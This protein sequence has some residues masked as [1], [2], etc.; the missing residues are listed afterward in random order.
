MNVKSFRDHNSIPLS[1]EGS[2]GFLA[3]LPRTMT[4][5]SPPYLVHSSPG[6]LL[7]RQRICSCLHSLRNQLDRS[8]TTRFLHLR[9][10]DANVTFDK[11]ITLVKTLR[12]KSEVSILAM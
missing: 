10:E 7:K 9:F 2:E 1:R 8:K 5:M 11:D 12:K 3:A 6:P 4:G